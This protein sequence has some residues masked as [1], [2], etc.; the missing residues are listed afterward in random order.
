MNKL[1]K[2]TDSKYTEYEELIDQRDTLLKEAMQNNVKF[3]QMFGDD[4]IKLFEL[5]IES[6]KYKKLI[7]YCTQLE[8][9][10]K[11]IIFNELQEYINL[12]MQSYYDDLKEIISQVSFAKTFT[13]VDSED[14]K[15]VK[16]I[17]FRIAK[18]IH[19]DRRP[20]LAN[21][22]TIKEFWNRT[23]LAYKLNDK[24][25]LIELEVATNKYLKDQNIDTADIEIEN[26]DQKIHD[27]EI[28]IE[29][30]LNTEP[31]TYKYI[32]EDEEEIKVLT[33]DYQQKIKKYKAY[34]KELKNK[35]S[36][37]KIQEIY[38]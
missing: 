7:R 34:I 22:E 14:T 4:I 33:D 28:E 31:Y 37:F 29:H 12:N 5:Q 25:S 26:I 2:T 30:I 19:P 38:S 24:K 32:L 1:I 17:Y 18:S 10:N 9:G 3:N 35:Y 15:A 36:K 16:K 8:N 20:D 13:I 21:D 23:V 6:I 27:L 11:P